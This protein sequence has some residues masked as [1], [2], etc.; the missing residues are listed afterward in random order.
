MLNT[1]KVQQAQQVQLTN[2]LDQLNEKQ[3]QLAEAQEIAKG[4]EGKRKAIQMIG[5]PNVNRS[6]SSISEA[7]SS[8]NSS[9]R[10]VCS[11]CKEVLRT[12]HSTFKMSSRKK[13]DIEDSFKAFVDRQDANFYQA[14]KAK[15][16]AD[17]L[18]MVN[19]LRTR[20]LLWLHEKKF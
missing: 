6:I 14:F 13:I 12:R 9:R 5:M 10:W 15:Q 4:T 3:I 11:K 8:S 19:L 2:T 17:V 16:D 7:S 18:E 1:Y 20:N